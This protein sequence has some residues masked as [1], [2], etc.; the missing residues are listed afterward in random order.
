MVNGKL[1]GA[2]QGGK[3]EDKKAKWRA[4]REKFIAAVRLGKQINQLEKDP[5]AK[6][7]VEI[8]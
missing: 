6:N 3:G 1:K 8:Q 5:N 2:P 7:D 4:E